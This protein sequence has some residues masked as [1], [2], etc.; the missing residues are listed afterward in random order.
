M[1]APPPLADQ[2]VDIELLRGYCLIGGQWMA[3]IAD[4]TQR[5]TSPLDGSE[6]ARVPHLTL[7]GIRKAINSAHAAWPAWRALTAQA[8]GDLLMAWHRQIL[9]HQEDLAT[10]LTAEQGKPLAEA[11]GEIAYAA[12]FV[13]W[14]AEEGKRV[15]G[16]TI[17][18][19]TKGARLLVTKEPVGVSAAITPWNFPAAMVTRK[20]APALAAGCPVIVKPASQTPLTA[21]ALGELAQ[22]AGLP[23]GVLNIITG[24]ARTIGEELTANP[25]VRKISFT[26]STEVGRR[27]LADA[28]RNIQKVTLE[29]GGNA[30]FI[31]LDDADLEA[32]VE[33]ALISKYRNTGQTCVCANRFFIQAGIYNAFAE[34]FSAA[35]ADLKVGSGFE[36]GVQQGPLIDP[37]ALTKVRVHVEDALEKGARVLVGG[38]R[39][40]LGGTFYQP[41]VLTDV[42]PEMR[43]CH[44]ETFGPVAPLLRF[45]DI[46][47]MLRTANDTP[48]GLAGYL[49]G[50]DIGRIFAVAEGLEV[51][52][53]GVNTGLISNAVAPFGGVKMSG[54][55][56]EGSRHGIDAYLEMKYICLGG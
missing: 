11:R 20:V 17:P 29:L 4:E 5:V 2:L 23:P 25:R 19:P 46:Q 26:G 51:G 21:L 14:F 15:Y 10:I 38:E 49:Y 55:G 39:H 13:E 8:R 56:R 34:R 30:P 18:S 36:E 45:D 43:I 7:A 16:E 31:V 48:F 3:A 27:L 22:R 52:M 44:E 42:T 9:D 6:I 35:V 12:T 41:T 40:D 37:A 50:R 28:A 32:A 54:I 53:V 24:N 47:A 33:G 1:P